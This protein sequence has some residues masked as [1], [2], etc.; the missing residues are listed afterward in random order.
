MNNKNPIIVG[1][2]LIIAGPVSAFCGAAVF[3]LSFGLSFPVLFYSI[4]AVIWF[5]GILG[6]AGGIKEARDK[7]NAHSN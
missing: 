6:I 7:R 1:V 5:L 2:A 3:A 4:W